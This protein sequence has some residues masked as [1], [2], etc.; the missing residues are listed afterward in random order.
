MFLVKL[1]LFAKKGAKPSIGL[2]HVHKKILRFTFT[3]LIDGRS[4]HSLHKS[5][6][7]VISNKLHRYCSNNNQH[8]LTVNMVSSRLLVLFMTAVMSS[9]SAA[10]PLPD[11]EANNGV[12]DHLSTNTP[13]DAAAAAVIDSNID[14]EAAATTT[15]KNK[16]KKKRD[17]QQYWWTY[18][19]T[20]SPSYFP[21]PWYGAPTWGKPTGRPVSHWCVSSVYKFLYASRIL[22]AQL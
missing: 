11:E 15:T 13:P 14:E 19:P 5:T 2:R 6:E 16:K 18:S 17:L 7:R 4:F 3:L 10:A 9:T 20:Y 8:H 1:I 12:V 22:C 21:T